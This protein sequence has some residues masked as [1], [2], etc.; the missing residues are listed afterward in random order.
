V[1]CNKCTLIEGGR[2]LSILLSWIHALGFCLALLTQRHLGKS[3]PLMFTFLELDMIDGGPCSRE[4]LFRRSAK[5]QT[6]Q[7]G[8]TLCAMDDEYY[9]IRL[10]HSTRAHTRCHEAALLHAS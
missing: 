5:A 2:L 8:E 3:L 6:S 7:D 9:R 1:R 10:Y 4:I